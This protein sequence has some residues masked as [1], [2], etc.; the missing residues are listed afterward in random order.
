MSVGAAP[1]SPRPVGEDDLHAFVDGRLGEGRRREVEAWLAAHPAEAARLREWQRHSA[2]LRAALGAVA[3]EAVPARL[4]LDALLAERRRRRTAAFGRMAAAAALFALGMAAGWGSARLDNREAAGPPMADALAAHRVYAGRTTGAVEIAA[5]ASGPLA[6]ELSAAAG[7]S[8]P[9]P[10][11]SELG[12]HPLG[13]RVLPSED[14]LAALVVY[15]GADGQRLSLFVR[16]S[17]RDGPVA[18]EVVEREAPLRAAVW[19]RGGFGH[20]VVGTGTPPGLLL[21]AAALS[22]G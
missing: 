17:R 13:G 9:V 5:M 19:F 22:R 3:E 11:L 15:E 8:V 2:A 14:G 1:A 7:W 4:R 18:P 16:R 10:D 6:A 20:A 21:H 12:L